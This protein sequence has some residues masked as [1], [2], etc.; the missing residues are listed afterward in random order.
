MWPAL[1][2]A[3]SRKERVP[4]WTPVLMVSII[5]R[6]GFSHAGAPPGSKP[7]AILVG[8]C[9]ILE[10]ISISHSGRPNERVRIR[11]LVTLKTYGKRPKRFRDVRKINKTIKKW[12]I[13][14]R[15]IELVRDA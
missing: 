13:T 15:L 12:C 9:I 10:I 6:N 11:W 8:A 4:G 14:G 5:T 1:I 3:A 2:L 7:A